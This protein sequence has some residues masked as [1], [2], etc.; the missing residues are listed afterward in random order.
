MQ[1][2]LFE[3]P[4]EKEIFTVPRKKKKVDSGA[5]DLFPGESSGDIV[6]HSMRG[7]SKAGSA[8]AEVTL[9]N[10]NKNIRS[11]DSYILNSG[12]ALVDV[13][14]S[15]I[16]SLDGHPTGRGLFAKTDINEGDHVCWY[17][18]KKM[19]EAEIKNSYSDYIFLDCD[20]ADYIIFLFLW[21]L[22]PGILYITLFQHLRT[23]QHFRYSIQTARNA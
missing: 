16:V 18:G 1:V 6:E 7:K 8:T 4:K 23:Y 5:T 21:T 15:K 13:Q 12:S 17:I 9:K 14:E 11:H 2:P 3:T 19:T 10:L 22:Y 20:A